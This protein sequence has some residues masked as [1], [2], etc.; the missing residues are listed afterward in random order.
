MKATKLMLGLAFVAA[1][2]LMMT[3]CK[4][5]DKNNYLS[6]ADAKA[7]FLAADEAMAALEKDIAAEPAI[8]AIDKLLT[9]GASYKLEGKQ[10][11]IALKYYQK[12][13]TFWNDQQ[14]EGGYGYN[15]EANGALTK[16]WDLTE[17]GTDLNTISF[18]LVDKDTAIVQYTGIA[19]DPMLTTN[20]SIFY[21][22]ATTTVLS[23]TTTTA[24]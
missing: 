18:P 16:A 4:K 19:K 13:F 17:S 21:P 2:G 14:L 22:N 20:A 24:T 3:S 11:H 5:K 15:M 1:A 6:V 12:F 8:K 10:P 7:A 23:T 9:K